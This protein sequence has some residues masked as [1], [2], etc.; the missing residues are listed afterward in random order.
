MS[1]DAM[2][3]LTITASRSSV[4]KRDFE[5]AGRVA[6][7]PRVMID[8]LPTKTSANVSDEFSDEV[9]HGPALSCPELIV[10]RGA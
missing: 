2:S 9:R 5:D 4:C 8:A 3:A 1:G 7:R 10:G 6:G